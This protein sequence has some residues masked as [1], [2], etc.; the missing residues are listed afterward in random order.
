MKQTPLTITPDGTL[1]YN[2]EGWEPPPVP[3]G[4]HRKS[5]DLTSR[6]AWIFIL[7]KPLCKHLVLHKIKSPACKCV[8]VIPACRFEEKLRI[9]MRSKCSKCSDWE[10]K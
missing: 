2:K 1:V 7:D 10:A 5:E 3:P 9:A 6:D 4:Y 8:R